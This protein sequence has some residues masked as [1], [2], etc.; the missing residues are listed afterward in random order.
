MENH[1]KMVSLIRAV[2]DDCLRDIYNKGKYRDVILPMV[3]LRRLDALLEDTKQNV[4]EVHK[5]NLEDGLGEDPLSLENASGQ[6]YYN[7]SPWT[8]QKLVNTAGNDVEELRMRVEEYL[9][10]YSENIKEIITKFK[11]SA[12]IS[13]MAEKNILLE[14]LQR[15]TDVNLNLTPY[16][17]ELNDGTILPGVSNLGMGYIF[18]ELIRRFNEENN[19][20]AGEHFTP[21]EVIELMTH[22]VFEPLEGQ[23][24]SLKTIYDPACGPGGM[25]TESEKFITDPNGKIKA[26]IP[27]KLYGKEINDETYAI[28]KSDM[29][30]KDNNPEGIK[31]GSTLSL[32]EFSD[33]KFDFML[34]NPPYGKSWKTEEK[35]IK[36]GKAVIDS[37][38]KVELTDIW[39]NKEEVDAIPANSDGQLLFLMEMVSKMKSPEQ[40]GIGSRIASVHNG[41]SLFTGDAGSGASNIRRYII[42][43]DLLDTV[44]QLPNNLFYNTGITTYIWLLNNNKPIERRGK[45]LLIDAN[46][47]YKK[48]RKSLGQKN[49]EITNEQVDE[50]VEIYMEMDNVEREKIGSKVFKN[51]DFGYYK[52]QVERPKRV[53]VDYSS[54]NISILKLN[55][56]YLE[57]S[58]YM[59]KKY[60]EN[61]IEHLKSN[62]SEVACD[63]KKKY[64]Y[65]KPKEIQALT[66]VEIWESQYSL[67][68]IAEQIMNEIGNYNS[69]DFNEFKSKF[70]QC[71]K[72]NGLKLNSSEKKKLISS[73]TTYNENAEK[74][75]S[76]S[77]KKTKKEVEK[78]LSYNN[79][80]IEQLKYFGY[81]VQDTKIVTYECESDLR[82]YEIMP[83]ENNL[84][85]YFT[86]EVVKYA[87]D[88]WINF[89]KTK[90]GYEISFNKYFYR[91][92]KVKSLE[93]ISKELM[94]MEK[95]SKVLLE[96][97]LGGIIYE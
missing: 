93:E 84:V 80:T 77:I 87:P 27:I 66:S 96:E 47:L 51:E 37:R 28:C 63:I 49:C 59:E 22:I 97:I 73:I 56:K 25:L 40:N 91:P 75:I 89:P 46:N 11:L 21:R 15:F 8:M 67:F 33:M 60:G 53:S 72:E 35:Y 64:E 85:D 90:I 12:Q 44:I 54:K 38:F 31:S 41:S 95:D 20:E 3:V 45:V 30:I 4:L 68:T 76:K 69:L 94:E 18:E 61:L 2:A 92:E 86:N 42:E 43:N 88:S 58:C 55:P 6:G 74:V 62:P 23:L 1:N 7:I 19:E 39:G 24:N 10:G 9:E 83:I 17:V 13:Y 29:I 5:E 52:I 14:V 32:D 78:L 70:E 65:L 34:S 16:D 57:E 48:R 71:V 26:N 81:E 50:I 82:G 79:C 36:D